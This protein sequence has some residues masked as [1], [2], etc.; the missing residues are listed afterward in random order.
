VPFEE[1]SLLK[2]RA[3]ALSGIKRGTWSPT[4]TSSKVRTL[5]MSSGDAEREVKVRVIDL[6]T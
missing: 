3:G 2:A 1:R 5:F 6:G 4:S